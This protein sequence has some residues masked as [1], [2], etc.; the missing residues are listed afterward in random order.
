M[1]KPSHRTGYIR[2]NHHVVEKYKMLMACRLNSIE[3]SGPHVSRGPRYVHLRQPPYPWLVSLSSINCLA[4]SWI[5]S[6]C[7]LTVDLSSAVTYAFC[8]KKRV[9]TS[10]AKG[11]QCTFFSFWW[12]LDVFHCIRHSPVHHDWKTSIWT[13]LLS[14][15]LAPPEYADKQRLLVQNGPTTSFFA[16]HF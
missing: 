8:P 12:V 5:V 2:E 13:G 6:S 15:C 7:N 16:L 9:V 1:V 3:F 10:L 4:A 14:R 11:V